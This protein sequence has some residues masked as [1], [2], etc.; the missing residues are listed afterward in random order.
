MFLVVI[1]GTDISNMLGFFTA[2]RLHQYPLIGS[3]YGA[4]HR[5]HCMAPSGPDCQLQLT[6]HL[7][8]PLIVPSFSCSPLPHHPFKTSITW[9]ILIHYQ[10]Q[11]HHKVQPWLLSLEHICFY[12]L[13][14]HFPLDFTGLFLDTANFLVS[15]NQCQLFQ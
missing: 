5:C 11:L 10:V 6:L 8:W 14:K 9:V 1:N 4:K 12:A 13:R 3:F 2:T 7:S 15:A